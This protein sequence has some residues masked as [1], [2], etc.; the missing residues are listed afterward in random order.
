M[1]LLASRTLERPLGRSGPVGPRARVITA[2]SKPSLLV[3]TIVALAC[4]RGEGPAPGFGGA[5]TIAAVPELP[6]PADELPGE[7][8]DLGPRAG[9]A[10]AV[11]GIAHDDVL[12]LRAALGEEREILATMESTQIGLIAQ[13]QT[14]SVP[15]AFWILVDL[16]GMLGWV[17]MRDVAY[18]GDTFDATAERLSAMLSATGERPSARTMTELGR[19]V[20]ESMRS[21]EA[22]PV[23]RI[24][25]VVDET[26]GDLGEVTLDLIGLGDDAL[27]GYR[28]HVFGEP[29]DGG[30][31]LRN[32]E[33]T[34][35]C[36]RG[37]AEGRL[38]L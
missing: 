18:L 16:N 28:V 9:D 34:N 38:C 20:T 15:G 11:V 24:V 31:S 13:G 25:V 10:L 21:P 37:V 27:R 17:N 14:R 6:G 8:V 3:A 5:D 36:A 23:P 7:P 22:E 26:L 35:L 19:I 33:V 12:P 30:F 2:S 29:V 4:G 32:V 1:G